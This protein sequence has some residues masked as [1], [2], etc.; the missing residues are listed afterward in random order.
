MFEWKMSL[1]DDFLNSLLKKSITFEKLEFAWVTFAQFKYLQFEYKLF[2]F[3]K[4][5][6]DFQKEISFLENVT[7]FSI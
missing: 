2:N 5:N 4:A 3:R 7:L 1:A 6:I